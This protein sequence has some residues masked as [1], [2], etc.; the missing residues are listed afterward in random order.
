MLPEVPFAATSFETFSYLKSRWSGIGNRVLASRSWSFNS[1][2]MQILLD[3]TATDVAI[4][5]PS[6]TGSLRR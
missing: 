2:R 3:L 6:G 4:G 5:V 1:N